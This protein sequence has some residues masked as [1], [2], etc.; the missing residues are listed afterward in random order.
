MRS[1]FLH[2]HPEGV[3]LTIHVQ[4]G[5]KRSQYAGLHGEALKVR[6]AAQPVEGAANEALCSFLAEL[7]NLP[8]RAI[9][10]ETGQTGRRK[11][12]LLKGLTSDGVLAVLNQMPEV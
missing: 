4:P 10:I 2:N 5:A 3:L 9:R 8:K 7:F 6:I 1:S 12:V 11:R